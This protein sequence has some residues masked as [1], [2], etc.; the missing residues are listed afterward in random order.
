MTHVIKKIDKAR[1]LAQY[2]RCASYMTLEDGPKPFKFLSKDG[3]TSPEGRA[4]CLDILLPKLPFQPHD[5]QLDGMCASLS[6]DLLAVLLTDAGKTGL[7]FMYMLVVQRF[8][9]EPNL[10]PEGTREYPKHPLMLVI[11][12]TNYICG[13][14]VENRHSV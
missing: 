6:Q 8:I 9:E 3:Y 1:R 2:T 7:L 10:R 11:C 14:K 12:L 4:L 13:A 5:Y